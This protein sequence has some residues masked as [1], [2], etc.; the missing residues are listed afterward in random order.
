MTSL[1]FILRLNITMSRIGTIINT[2]LTPRLYDVDNSFT[3]PFFVG[4]IFL[5]FSW[6]TGILLAIMDKKSDVRDK[7]IIE[8]KLDD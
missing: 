5:A 1:L 3:L 7:E 6:V 8:A 4:I 2:T